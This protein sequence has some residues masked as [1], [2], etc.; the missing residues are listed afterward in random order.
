MATF[1]RGFRLVEKPPVHHIFDKDGFCFE[2]SHRNS[3]LVQDASQN[4]A[5]MGTES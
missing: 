3:C 2:T 1:V 4:E 5:A